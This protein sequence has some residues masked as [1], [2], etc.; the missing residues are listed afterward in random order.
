MAWLPSAWEG[1]A[2]D[3]KPRFG[4]AGLDTLVWGVLSLSNQGTSGNRSDAL[5][6]AARLAMARPV[7][8]WRVKVHVARSGKVWLSLARHGM[9]RCVMVSLAW[10]GSLWL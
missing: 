7:Q 1:K 9:V 10:R 8:A 6:P 4:G 3:G 5:L 2:G